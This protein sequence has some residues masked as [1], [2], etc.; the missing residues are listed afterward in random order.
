MALFWGANDLL[1]DPKDVYDLAVALPNLVGAYQVGGPMWSHL[2]FVW[3]INDGP[4]INE[5]LI[6]MMPRF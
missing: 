2:D 1:A 3:G 5:R 4:V 6:E